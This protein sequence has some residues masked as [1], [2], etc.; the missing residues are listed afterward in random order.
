MDLL[1]STKAGILDNHTSFSE[2]WTEDIDRCILA[3]NL[4]TTNFCVSFTL[5]A[6]K[7]RVT[8]KYL[9]NKRKIQWKE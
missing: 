6:N 3:E 8:I 4:P 9:T 2:T 7:Y 5:V 1:D